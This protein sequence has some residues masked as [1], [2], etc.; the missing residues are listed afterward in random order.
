MNQNKE[1]M[2]VLGAAEDAVIRA[3]DVSSFTR[4]DMVN[5]ILQRS[6]VLADSPNG[7]SPIKSWM[8]G[9]SGPILSEVDRLGEE[10]ARR[11]AGVILA[12]YRAMSETV[13]AAGP[14]RIADIGCGYAIWDLFASRDTG[15]DLLL[16]DIEENEHRHFGFAEQ[17]AAYTSLAA[18]GDFLK[19]NGVAADKITLLNPRA[20]DLAA[21]GPV[22][23]AVSFISCGF[24]YPVD[25]YLDFFRDQVSPEGAVL[26]DLRRGTAQE[27][28]AK[29][30]DIGRVADEISSH[31]KARRI[32][33]R[34]AM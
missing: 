15:A 10:I 32:L 4:S 2:D 5:L 31:P 11:A 12:E 26:I 30:S 33:L 14:K 22:D 8:G 3:L 28:L 16:I 23:L 1:S 9:D 18:A 21:A 17:G 19:R 25:A 20:A 29:L 13:M 27:Q 7:Q 34:K 24:H 6:E